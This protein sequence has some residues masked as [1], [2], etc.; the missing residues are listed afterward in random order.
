[1]IKTPVSQNKFF[2][3]NPASSPAKRFV[4]RFPYVSGLAP[5]Q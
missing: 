1:M 3:E 4:I 5:H 2:V